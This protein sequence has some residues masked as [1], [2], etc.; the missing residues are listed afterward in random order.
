MLLTRDLVAEA[1][2]LESRARKLRSRQ[3]QID[4]IAQAA[5]EKSGKQ[6]I[7]RCGFTIAWIAGRAL[8]AWKDEFIRACGVEAADSLAANAPAKP[9]LQITP[10]AA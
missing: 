5:L 1:S 7:K 10:P 2:A 8:V 3:S 9:K 4:A 6:T